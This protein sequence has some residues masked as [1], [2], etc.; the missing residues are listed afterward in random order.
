[1]SSKKLLESVDFHIKFWNSTLKCQVMSEQLGIIC[2]HFKDFLISHGNNGFGGYIFHDMVWT[3]VLSNT[4][5]LECCEMETR[6]ITT[7]GCAALY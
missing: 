6:L 2:K 7:H 5:D 4:W 3:Y 1:M